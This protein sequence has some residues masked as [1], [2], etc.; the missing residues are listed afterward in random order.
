MFKNEISMQ[1]NES[2]KNH[3]EWDNTDTKR[4]IWYIFAHMLKIAANLSINSLQ[5]T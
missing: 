3:F 4:Q 1:M 2:K 5:P